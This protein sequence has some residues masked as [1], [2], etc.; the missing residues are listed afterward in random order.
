MMRKDSRMLR[1]FVGCVLLLCSL[2]A[3][4]LILPVDG[5]AAK[6]QFKK[7]ECA[8]CHDDFAKEYLG[9]KNQHP[10]VKDGNCLDCH[11]SHGIVGKLLLV[12]EGNNLCFRCHEKTSFNLDEKKGVHTAL[13]RG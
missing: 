12:E 10:G 4:Q 11:L 1:S 6:R 3:W 9:M 7:K 2:L 5:H 8:D 13:K